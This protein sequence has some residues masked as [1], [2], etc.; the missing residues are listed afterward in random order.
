MERRFGNNRFGGRGGGR[1]G[2]GGGF[3]RSFGPREMH[4]A[5]CS[6]CGKQCQVP[7][8]PA[9]DE[10][11]NLRPVYC[12]DCFKKRKAAERGETLPSKPAEQAEESEDEEESED[13]E[14]F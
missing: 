6:E 11:G 8:V 3:R 10:N 2:S 5:T 1:G 14:D 7:F 9:K 13:S 12:L 4:D